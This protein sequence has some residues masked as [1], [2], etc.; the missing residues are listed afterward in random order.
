MIFCLSRLSL[1]S[2]ALFQPKN[3]ENQ[4]TFIVLHFL[5]C[6]VYQPPIC[7]SPTPVFAQ[8]KKRAIDDDIYE[9]EFSF[10]VKISMEGLISLIFVQLPGICLGLFGILKA[11]TS[12]GLSKEAAV[13]SLRYSKQS[14][15]PS[16]HV[17]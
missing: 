7:C 5:G 11:F 16:L 12:H 8:R 6:F 1:T 14:I 15:L 4:N 2:K 10:S 13:D 3:Q 9:K 17:A